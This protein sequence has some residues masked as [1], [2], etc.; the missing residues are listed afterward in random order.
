L[1]AES[2]EEMCIISAD[3][4]KEQPLVVDLRRV[5]NPSWSPDGK[6]LLFTGFKDNKTANYEIFVLDITQKG[7]KPV[8]LTRHP[9]HD[10]SPSWSPDGKR[11]AFHSDRKGDLDL[12]VM[13]ADGTH[14]K[15]VTNNTKASGDKFEYAKNWQKSK[16]HF[17]KTS[18]SPDSQKIAFTSRRNGNYDIYTIRADGSQLRQMTN[19]PADDFAPFWA[20]H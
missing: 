1:W 14:Q 13:N 6:Y 10:I 4:V 3:G 5:E 9:G 15:N 11:I 16:S 18:W 2:R 17:Y 20:N 12:F 8:N 7:V 19:G